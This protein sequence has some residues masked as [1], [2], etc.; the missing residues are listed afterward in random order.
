MANFIPIF[1]L[2]IGIVV[3]AGDGVKINKLKVPKLIKHGSP[4]VI[5]DCDFTLEDSDEEP[6]V[7]WFFNNDR[8]LVYQWIPGKRPQDSGILKGRLKLEYKA[9]EDPNCL[10]RALYILQ[11]GPDLSGNYTCLVSTFQSEEIR[12]KSMLVYV[13]GKNLALK[14]LYSNMEFT[15]VECRAEGAFPRPELVLRLPEYGEINDTQIDIKQQGLLY[16]VTAT[17][18]IPTP[19]HPTDVSCVL[20]IPGANYTMT[21]ETVIFP[22]SS[23]GP[24]SIHSCGVLLHVIICTFMWRF[25]AAFVG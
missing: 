25:P 7:K 16:D 12:T 6:V 20:N 22:G 14:V 10:H 21:Q 23:K 15:K 13:P 1:I 9:S 4:S 3:Q 19:P 17:A 11:P 5:L 2:I 24:R 8:T 18:T